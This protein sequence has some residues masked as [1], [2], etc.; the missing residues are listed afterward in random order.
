MIYP[1][2]LS[3]CKVELLTNE[4]ISTVSIPE[5]VEPS[6]DMIKKKLNGED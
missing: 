3:G 2:T 6:G 5:Y 1:T 4:T